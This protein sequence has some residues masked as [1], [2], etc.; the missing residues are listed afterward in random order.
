MKR[1]C[2]WWLLAAFAACGSL[3]AD[4]MNPD[5][6]WMVGKI[7]AFMHYLPGLERREL[8]KDFDVEGLKKQLVEM[9]ADFFIFTLGQN[10]NFYNAPNAAFEKIAG[11]EAKTRLSERDLPAE[12]IA[13]LNP[14]TDRR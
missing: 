9:K 3:Q 6:D 12:L 8:V 5:T 13:A 7:G 14:R 4:P 10:E 1:T 11:P 2:G